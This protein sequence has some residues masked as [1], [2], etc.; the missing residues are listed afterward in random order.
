MPALDRGQEPGVA[1]DETGSRSRLVEKAALSFP[2]QPRKTGSAEASDDGGDCLGFGHDAH[3][4]VTE[5]F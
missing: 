2:R 4:N 5:P 1:G 3:A